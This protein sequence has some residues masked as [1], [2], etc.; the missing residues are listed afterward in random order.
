MKLKLLLS[1]LVAA[2]LTACGGGDESSPNAD[3]QGFWSG[4][5]STGY[6]VNTVILNTGEVWGV[7]SQG[8]TIWGA[9]YGSATVS[10]QRVTVQGTDFNFATNSASSGTLTGTLVPR[11]SLQLSSTSGVSTSLSYDASYE[12]AATAAAITGTWS[13]VG[14][15]GAFE[16]VPES[17]T[18]DGTG[19]F[20]L[21]QADCTSSGSIVPRPGGKNIYD[22]N[23]TSVGSA[24]ALGYSTLSGVA[25]LDTTVS[26]NRF[27]ALG[28]T[29][30]KNDGLIVIGTKA[31]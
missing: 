1:V 2:A 24:C 18:V 20:T 12:T 11:S 14:R 30:S 10:G 27:L 5:A 15:S 28:L 16:L 9:L 4:P 29:P 21:S 31:P 7:Y 25:Y 23:L 13:F 22:F 17:V 8:A 26:P 3:P 6:T 19:S